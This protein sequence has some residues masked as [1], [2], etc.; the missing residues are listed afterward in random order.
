MCKGALI[1]RNPQVTSN[2]EFRVE[3]RCTY[4]NQIWYSD[5]PASLSTNNSELMDEPENKSTPWAIRR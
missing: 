4:C 2:G 5:S 3:L 1:T